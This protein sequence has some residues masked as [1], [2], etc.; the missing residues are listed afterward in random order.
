MG[1]NINEIVSGVFASRAQV[2]NNKNKNNHDIIR[3]ND[4]PPSTVTVTKHLGQ[5][6]VSVVTANTATTTSTAGSASSA[7]SSTST[8]TFSTLTSKVSAYREKKAAKKDAVKCQ[9][10][11]GG[12]QTTCNAVHVVDHL[13]TKDQVVIFSK[14]YCPYCRQV[15]DLLTREGIAYVAVELD[16]NENGAAVQRVLY[17]STGQRTVPVV[18]VN[19]RHIGGASDTLAKW[20]SGELSALLKTKSKR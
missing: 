6:I 20:E 7:A 8:S 19:G 12:E 1:L 9:L 17:Q 16:L 3:K 14:S 15:K 10:C 5:S 18:F 13:V 2:A 4:A 11:C